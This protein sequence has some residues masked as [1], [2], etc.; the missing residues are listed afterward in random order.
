MSQIDITGKSAKIL[1][2][3]SSITDAYEVTGPM[4]VLPESVFWGLA[5]TFFYLF[6]I[7]MLL[8]I[9]NAIPAVP[10]DGGYVFRDGMMGFLSRLKP[11]WDKKTQEKYI[12]T[13]S[14]SLAFLI[15]ILILMAM[16]GPYFFALFK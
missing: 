5:N 11:S 13:F 16:F 6:W 14:L 2:F 12:T 4:S 9:F 10:L 15:L 1:P 8:G 3:K 7:N